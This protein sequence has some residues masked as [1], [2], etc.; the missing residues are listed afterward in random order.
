[1][2]KSRKKLEKWPKS[3]ACLF[4]ASVLFIFILF[5]APPPFSPTKRNQLE[6]G[7]AQAIANALVDAKDTS[8]LRD[9][10]LGYAS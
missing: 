9:L 7:G 3:F 2:K 10:G 8:G 6:G 1:M 4:G 5:F